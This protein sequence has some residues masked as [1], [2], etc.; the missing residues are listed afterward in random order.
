M[1]AFKILLS[2]LSIGS[3]FYLF[4]ADILNDFKVKEE[5]K[6]VT[7]VDFPTNI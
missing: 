3:V 2:V 6:E 4:S 1:I 7:E 5:I